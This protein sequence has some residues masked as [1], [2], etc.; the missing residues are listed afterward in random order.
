[1]TLA[2]ATDLPAGDRLVLLALADCANDE[3]HCWPG[4]ASLSQKTGM[5]KRSLQEAM[6]ML[7]KGRH[8]TRTENP[9][10]GMNYVVHPV[11]KSAPVERTAPVAKSANGGGKDC[12]GGVAKSA[13]KPSEN[14]KNRHRSSNDDSSSGDE[15]ALDVEEVFQG[16]RKLMSDLGLTVPRDLTPERRQLLR[17]RIAQY[18]LADFQE[19]F[20]RC[21][22]SPFLRG[23]KGRTPLK[24][25]WL[26]KKSNFQKVLEG[27]YD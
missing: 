21:R 19:V 3:G 16:F 7:D 8:I 10:K 11:A 4:L 1:M 9:G 2:W 6:R 20:A 22:G 13:P 25:D 24:F 27:N 14:H 5:C 17:F 18:D 15:P 12:H 23:D 26:F